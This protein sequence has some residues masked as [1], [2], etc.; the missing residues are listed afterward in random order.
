V[1]VRR[2]LSA[3]ADGEFCRA[4]AV[5]T[6]GNPFLVTEALANLRQNGTRPVTAEAHRV[7]G[8]LHEVLLSA[9]GSLS[10]TRRC[11]SAGCR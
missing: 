8:V 1:L 6:G 4:C 5:A 10:V 7:V 9:R 3:D 2:H 11:D